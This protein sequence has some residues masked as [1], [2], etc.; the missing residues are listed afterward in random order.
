VVDSR[1][2]PAVARVLDAGVFDTVGSFE[3]D[4]DEDFDF[5]LQLYLDGVERFIE[6]VCQDS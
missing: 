2:L 5:G 6:R 3:D 4:S 1:Q